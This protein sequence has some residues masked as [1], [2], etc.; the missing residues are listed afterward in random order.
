MEFRYLSYIT[1]LPVYA[2]KANKVFDHMHDLTS[3][4]GLYPIFINPASG[5]SVGSQV[6]DG[7]ASVVL[8][9]W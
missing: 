2:E 5:K 3:K 9:L 1:G 7:C 4:D 6:W 8:G